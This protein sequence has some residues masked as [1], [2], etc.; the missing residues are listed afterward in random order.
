[1]ASSKQP[2]GRDRYSCSIRAQVMY[3][4]MPWVENRMACVLK[5]TGLEKLANRFNLAVS[6]GGIPSNR[7]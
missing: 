2:L 1:M 3:R 6:A 5:K 7:E 4:G